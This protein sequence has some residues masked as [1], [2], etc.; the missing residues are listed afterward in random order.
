MPAVEYPAMFAAAGSA[1]ISGERWYARLVELDLVLVALA[2]LTAGVGSVVPIGWRQVVAGFAV[3]LIAGAALSRWVNRAIRRDK[4]WF[5][6]RSVAESVKT[7]SWRYMMRAAPFSSGSDE[8]DGQFVRELGEILHARKDL[9][10]DPTK[11]TGPQ[12]TSAMRDVRRRTFNERKEIYVENRLLDQVTW[13][14]NRANLHRKLAKTWF[15][16]GI[17]AELIA[18]VWAVV[19]VI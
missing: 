1:G 4:T 14:S 11:S 13:Y 19:R 15:A 8:A 12:I 7:A 6:G 18:L 10:L 16:V 17:A 5:D 2:A 3:L 9:T